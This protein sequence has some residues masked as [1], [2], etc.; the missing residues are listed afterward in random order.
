MAASP[1][2]VK[3]ME[4]KKTIRKTVFSR[5]A[6]YTDDEIAKMS[7]IITEK[8]T[9]SAAFCRAQRIY[10]YVD[11]NH[12]VC[13]RALIEAAWKAGKAVAVPKVEGRDLVFYR[14]DRFSS[15]APGYYGILEPVEGE[16]VNWDDALMI[17]PGVAFDRT[18]HRI[19]YG[20]GFYDRFLEHRPM[21][22]IALAF[23]FQIFEELPSEE[24]D[25][26]P[27]AVYT[28]ENVY[29]GPSDVDGSEDRREADRQAAFLTQARE[30]VK[31]QALFCGHPLTAAVITFGCQMNARD[32]EKLVGILEAAGYLITEDEDADFVIYNTCSVRENANT[33]LYG[34]LGKQKNLMKKDPHRLVALCGCMMQEEAVVQLIRDRYPFV[35]LIFGTHNLY[36]FPE[37]L[38]TALKK[39]ELIVDIRKESNQIVEDLP[40][41]RKYFFKSGINIM[42]GC[43]NFCSYCIVPYVRGRE[44]SRRPQE[45]L[46]EIRRIA[47]QGVVEVM[48]LGQNVNSYGK[49]LT[50]PLSFAALLGEV[51]KIEGIRRIR[52]MTSHPKDLSD[53]LLSVM[54][55]SDKICHHIHLPLQS[56]S[57]RILKAMNRRYTKESYL[58]LTERIKR[59]VPDV[60]LTTDIIVGFP[61]ETE[62]DFEDT[63]DV[64]R[65]VRFDNAFTFLYSKRNGTP[66]ASMEEQIPQEVARERFDR[67]LR[68]VQEIA[69]ANT[70]R[71]EGSIDKVLVEQ[72][73]QQD[74][75]LVTGRLDCNLLVH[76]PG[77]E[78]LIGQIV[79]VRLLESKGFYYI[80]EMIT[81]G[82]LT[83]DGA[84]H[85]NE[86][87]I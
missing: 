37:L 74:A 3:N 41:H 4:T 10:C 22:K 36:Q 44:R 55:S 48:L 29:E 57:S 24:T 77:D 60:S 66:A 32:S 78:S 20:G 25:I 82:T 23:E 84:I 62:E 18:A 39:Q 26:M 53:E 14:L 2:L 71:R 34:H 46:E 21:Q 27:D 63:L 64:V 17:M 65:R 76:F 87:R 33:K 15:L 1:T 8:V 86:R 19:G 31:Q 35:H 73:N 28:E 6:D 59:A 52:F 72:I 49:N 5:R 13:T 51:E 81:D 12:E 54:A 11:Y 83:D 79:D 43:N 70:A 68:E 16:A 85:Q 30:L 56:G 9:A 69:R 58:A 47:A 38:V 75:S 80:G 42:Y 40:V 7:Q 61:G 50:D 67:L 45:I